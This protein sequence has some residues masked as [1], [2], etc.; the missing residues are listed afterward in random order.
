MS[1]EE[2]T[3]KTKRSLYYVI[4]KWFQPYWNP[5]PKKAKPKVEKSKSTRGK[6]TDVVIVESKKP[7]TRAFSFEKQPKIGEIWTF[8]NDRYHQ[9]W[10]HLAPGSGYRYKSDERSSEERK[11]LNM[12]IRPADYH[13]TIDRTHMLP[14]GYTGFEN[15]ERF[16]IG[17]SAEA[18]RGPFNDFEQKQKARKEPIYW[19]CS[20]ERNVDKCG[21]TWRYLIFNERMKLIDSL[22]H[23]MDNEFIWIDYREASKE[24][25]SRK[26]MRL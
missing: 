24:K 2:S 23:T 9:I 19:M 20:V 1:K 13:G 5:K 26:K 11:L 12:C 14:F 22:E 21:A 18:N 15:D 6:E 8:H 7:L 16:L 4:R 25:G 10:C 3:V 17:W